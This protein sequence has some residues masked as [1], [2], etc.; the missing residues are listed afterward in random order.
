[1]SRFKA[2]QIQLSAEDSDRL[3]AEAHRRNLPID[4]LAAILLHERLVHVKPVISPQETLLKLREIGRKMPPADALQLAQES[5]AELE[6]R[7]NL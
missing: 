5:R 1:M 4:V 7:G 2:I 3:E 6:Q